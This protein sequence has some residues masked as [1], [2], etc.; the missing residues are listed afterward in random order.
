MDTGSLHSTH[1]VLSTFILCRFYLNRPNLIVKYRIWLFV[2]SF[3]QSSVLL[4]LLTITITITITATITITI[5]VT[6][7]ITTITT[8]TTTIIFVEKNF[9]GKKTFLLDSISYSLSYL[10][11]KKQ[12]KIICNFSMFLH[13]SINLIFFSRVKVSS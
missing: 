13:C 2:S 11:K 5:T 1:V 8:T 7:T 6:I 10:E 9:K 12:T 4:L 3:S